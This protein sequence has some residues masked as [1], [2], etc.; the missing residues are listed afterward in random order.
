MNA[1]SELSRD[2][3]NEP[4]PTFH[5]GEELARSG[6]VGIWADRTDLGDTQQFARALRSQAET[7]QGHSDAAGH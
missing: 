5:T 3:L 4:A 1:N 6:L 7:R 2:A